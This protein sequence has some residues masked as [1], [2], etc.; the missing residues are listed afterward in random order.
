MAI[1]EKPGFVPEHVAK[2]RAPRGFMKWNRESG[3]FEY[4]VEGV[5]RFAFSDFALEMIIGQFHHGEN[6]GRC[7]IVT[8]THG[9]HLVLR[10]VPITRLREFIREYYRTEVP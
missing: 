5:K 9:G 1:L 8:G 7:A 10:S 6:T 2:R 3:E 4:W